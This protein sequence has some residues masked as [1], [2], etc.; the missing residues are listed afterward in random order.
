MRQGKGRWVG[1]DG[2]RLR[3]C[4][5][6]GM[7]GVG[8]GVGRWQVMLPSDALCWVALRIATN[9][10]AN[11]AANTTANTAATAVGQVVWQTMGGKLVHAQGTLVM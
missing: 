11:T 7:R 6:G 1:G 9:T 2:V 5:C 8:V 10:A 4:V 3:E